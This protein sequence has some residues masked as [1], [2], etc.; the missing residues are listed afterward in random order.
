[1]FSI[2][3]SH[4]ILNKILPFSQPKTLT[5]ILFYT[6]PK[7]I[8]FKKFTFL[9]IAIHLFL[10]SFSFFVESYSSPDLVKSDINSNQNQYS[11]VLVGLD[12]NLVSDVLP[13][14]IQM[15]YDNQTYEG[16]PVFYIYRGDSSFS[17]FQKPQFNL[18][19]INTKVKP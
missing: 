19:N 7:T 9:T 15:I 1:L 3:F 5:E 11:L 2:K 14:K 6:L 12:N 10:V 17:D 13:A 18:S 8:N 16:K 4:L